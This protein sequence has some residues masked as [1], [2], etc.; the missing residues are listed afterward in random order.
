M[1]KRLRRLFTILSVVFVG[2]ASMSGQAIKI[3]G[4]LHNNRYDDGDQL[5]SEYVGW[6]SELGKAIFI[7]DLG[8]YA[9]TWDGTKLS[10][11]VKE[12]AVVK[13][14][15]ANDNDKQVWATNFNL[16]YG[17]SGAVH[18]GNKLI[19]VTSRDYQSTEDNELFA[20]RKWDAVNGNLLNDA[21]EFLDVS[22]NIESA[23]MS[24]NPV[25]GKIYGFFHITDAKLLD[26]ILEDEDYF[27]EQDDV[28]SG[29]ENLDDGYCLGTID[30]KTMKIT[31]IT[32]GLYYGNFIAFAINSEGRAF[33]LTSGGTTGFL[34]DDGKIYN[35]NN[36]LTG[37]RL[38][39]LDTK[40]GLMVR[41]SKEVV[42]A[43]TGEKYIEYSY[44]IPATGYCSQVRRQAACFS[45]SN[46][47]KFYWVGFYNSGKGVNSNGSWTTLDNREWK[48]NGLFDTALYEIDIKTGLC[49]RLAKVP[50]RVSF[51]CIWIDG[52]DPSDGVDMD[53][54]GGSGVDI[55][56]AEDSSKKIFDINGREVKSMDRGLYIVKE[57][58]KVS[59]V[60]I[61]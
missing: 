54:V 59:K 60:M 61:P 13:S 4:V 30:P 21:N 42:D 25:D 33:T 58:G 32:P 17:N 16:M 49:T 57:G 11:P 26:E 9:M 2:T 51:S 20:V 34:G 8:I 35:I 36:E 48:T 24:Y 19:T 41:D 22:A 7:V 18:V 27:T 23:G 12:P 29:R 55:I 31:P 37:A 14:E 39:E 1:N 38:I 56:S 28:D 46:P 6:N 50:N 53:M 52:D 10:T 43:A 47:D 45:K 40:T 5:K 44:P 3:K 15:I